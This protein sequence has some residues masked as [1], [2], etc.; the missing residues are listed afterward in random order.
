MCENMDVP[1]YAGKFLV[2]FLR[3]LHS[4]HARLPAATLAG[5]THRTMGDDWAD[6]SRRACTM[7]LSFTKRVE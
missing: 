3:M 5:S 2:I 1:P 7:A 6:S 4:H